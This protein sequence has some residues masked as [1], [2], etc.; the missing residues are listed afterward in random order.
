MPH[1]F[2]HLFEA[3]YLAV[4]VLAARRGYRI[5]PHAPT[6]GRGTPVCSGS[7]SDT[8][9]HANTSCPQCAYAAPSEPVYNRYHAF[10]RECANMARKG[11]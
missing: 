7:A 6:G 5:E 8:L 1:A 10:G 2:E 11:R 9:P 3:G 4:K